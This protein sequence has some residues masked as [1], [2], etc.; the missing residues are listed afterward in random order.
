MAASVIEVVMY[1][2]AALAFFV[3]LGL[4]ITLGY[5]ILSGV[6][7][8]LGLEPKGGPGIFIQLLIPTGLGFWIGE[9]LVLR[10]VSRLADRLERWKTQEQ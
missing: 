7:S 10:R 9:R 5:A 4:T 1:I 8:A 6:V 3:V 2:G